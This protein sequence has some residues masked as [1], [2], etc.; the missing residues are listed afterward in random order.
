MIIE[1][2]GKAD[3]WA[4]SGTVHEVRAFWTVGRDKDGAVKRAAI[5]AVREATRS[6]GTLTFESWDMSTYS[7]PQLNAM[8]RIRERSAE[9][10]AAREEL[11]SRRYTT[12]EGPGE[13]GDGCEET[14]G[15][16]VH[17]KAENVDRPLCYGCRR[18]IPDGGYKVMHWIQRDGRV[19]IN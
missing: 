10:V 8:I 4:G 11:K 1:Y 3:R 18:L 16:V 12:C 13:D 19:Q 2:V 17:V 7:H 14:P 9:E 15:E 6:M 5:E